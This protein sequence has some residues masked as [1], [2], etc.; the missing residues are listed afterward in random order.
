MLYFADVILPLALDKPYTY[1]VEKKDYLILKPGFRVAVSLG[2]TKIYTGVVIKLHHDQPENYAAKYIE[3]VLEQVPSISIKQI[4]LWEW[5][6]KYY[7]CKLGEIM[8]AALPSN[9]LLESETVIEKKV[10]L[11]DQPEMTDQEYIIFESLDTKALNIKEIIEILGRKS[12]L[13]L[14]QNMLSKGLIDQ[15][16]I[17]GLSPKK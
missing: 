13:G 10:I 12:V 7:H 8:R 6:S 15:S 3:M 9:L 1:A 4:E 11:G 5:I 16:A 2:K 17:V 14:I